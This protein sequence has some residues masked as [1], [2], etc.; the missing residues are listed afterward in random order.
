MA[1]ENN[2][3]TPPAKVQ[4]A[5]TVGPTAPVQILMFSTVCATPPPGCQC[6]HCAEQRAGASQR[7]QLVYHAK[8]EEPGEDLVGRKAS[9]ETDQ[10]DCIEYA[11]AAGDMTDQPGHEGQN[12][13]C[14]NVRIPDGRGMR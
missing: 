14:H 6:L 4:P 13:H 7:D 2:S 11:E 10:D 8:R 9:R 12:V 1:F 3:T 5:R